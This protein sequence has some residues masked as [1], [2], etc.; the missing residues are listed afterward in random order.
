MK[1]H[2]GDGGRWNAEIRYL[3][4]HERMGTAGPLGLID[5]PPEHPVFVMNGDLL[6]KVDFKSLA[7][8]HREQRSEA[9]MCVR[10]YDFQ[11]PFGVVEIE[12]NTITGIDE[13]PQHRF[14]VN[15]GI[16]VINPDLLDLI[17]KGR[18]FDMTDFF[19]LLVK[20]G[21]DTAGFPI[22]E[23]WLDIGRPDDLR[24]AH[25]AY[26]QHFE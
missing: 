16:Y 3:H 2:F 23:F 20:A 13:K 8:Y 21:H 9:T 22:Q 15:A 24:Q 14:F 18:Y 25:T 7:S 19:D 26:E 5:E 17:P 4:E 1:A 10:E 12:N 6:T 11:V